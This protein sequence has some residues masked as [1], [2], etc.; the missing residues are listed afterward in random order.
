MKLKESVRI[1][2]RTMVFV[3]NVFVNVLMDI[4]EVI[5]RKG[6]VQRRTPG[7]IRRRRTTSVTIVRNVRIWARAIEVLD[8]VTVEKDLQELRAN[9]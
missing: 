1:I 9:E 7:S 4:L 6:I 8:Y 3:R 2:V 5:V